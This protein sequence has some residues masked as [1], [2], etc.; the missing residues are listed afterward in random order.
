MR[1]EGR[2]FQDEY[3]QIKARLLPHDFAQP[4]ELAPADVGVVISLAGEFREFVE[5][6]GSYTEHNGTILPTYQFQRGA[7]RIVATFVGDMG[8]TSATRVTERMISFWRP[9]TIITVGLAAAISDE[10]HIG[11]VFIPERAIQYIQNVRA[12]MIPQINAEFTIVPGSFEYH[13]DLTSHAAIRQIEQANPDLIQHF[14]Q[15]C[16]RDLEQ[17]IADKSIREQLFQQIIVRAEVRQLANGCIATGPVVSSAETFARWIQGH[18]RTIRAV[19]MESSAA[20]WLAA[21]SP[22]NPTR[23]LTIRG[24]SDYGGERKKLF[25]RTGGA[26]RKYAMRNALRFLMALCDAN[27]LPRHN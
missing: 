14:R 24:V 25:D 19:E 11:D 8:E 27:V 20:V 21:Q 23:S 13:A 1:R 2:E 18:D 15:T 7:H 10:L 26:L 9:C 6:F 12:L 4:T 3:N 17:L 22:N 16:A 5:L